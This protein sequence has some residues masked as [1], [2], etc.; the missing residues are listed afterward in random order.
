MSSHFGI[1]FNPE[2]TEGHLA[3]LQTD[4]AEMDRARDSLVKHLREFGAGPAALNVQ[5]HSGSADGIVSEVAHA[6]RREQPHAA[7]RRISLS[8]R[9]AVE[10]VATEVINDSVILE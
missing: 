6:I 4:I 7:A 5:V 8:K 9:I 10:A 3:T 2:I 1:D